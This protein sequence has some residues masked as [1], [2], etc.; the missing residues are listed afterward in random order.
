MALHVTNA[1]GP[2]P[3]PGAKESSSKDSAANAKD[4][5]EQ[6][7]LLKYVQSLLHAVIQDKPEDPFSYMIEQLTA[8][9]SKSQTCERVMSRPTSARPSRPTS[10]VA[11]PA[12]SRPASARP[13]PPKQRPVDE[14]PAPREDPPPFPEIPEDRPL[15]DTKDPAVARKL[16]ELDQSA[17]KKKELM[18][19]LLT[20]TENGQLGTVLASVGLEH[21]RRRIQALLEQSAESG[22]LEAALKMVMNQK[23]LMDAQKAKSDMRGALEEAS[24]TEMRAVLGEMKSQ[25][26]MDEELA[27]TDRSANMKLWQEIEAENERLKRQ[28]RDTL[29]E[30]D[31]SGKMR[32]VLEEMVG[33]KDA[34]AQELQ[35]SKDQLKT[36]LV[37]A[38]ESGKKKEALQQMLPQEPAE[39]AS[40][41]PLAVGDG[42]A[43]QDERHAVKKKLCGAMLDAAESGKLAEV[44]DGRSTTDPGPVTAAPAAGGTGAAVKAEDELLR[45]NVKAKM[46]E[47]LANGRLEEGLATLARKKS[48]EPEKRPEEDLKKLGQEI[49]GVLQQASQ[50]GKLDEALELLKQE[51]QEVMRAAPEDEMDA[52]RKNLCSLMQDAMLSG[53]LAVALEELKMKSE[54]I[55]ATD[56]AA[57]KAKFRKLLREALESGTLASKVGKLKLIPKA[58]S[59]PKGPPPD[60]M[61]L[62]KLH[63]REALQHAAEAGHLAEALASLQKGPSGDVVQTKLQLQSVLTEAALSGTLG[64]TLRSL[65]KAREPGGATTCRCRALCNACG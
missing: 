43:R 53:Q 42:V 54:D 41:A 30:A 14:A 8:A 40:V 27:E 23:E 7:G 12:G 61:D 57:I 28:L 37:E 51:Q 55:K 50:S 35:D 65:R 26:Q 18:R 22:E 38:S 59:P 60:E 34:N 52:V 47:S 21:S 25:R 3:G 63:L 33:A 64:D 32:T 1:E 2:G 24:E 45:E 17:D 49:C 46:Q 58:P 62:L 48:Q 5:L 44:L 39:P 56:V 29:L 15:K 36:V 4:Y 9:Q 13:N 10:A 19:K 20:A 16:Q 11:R 6:K 31:A